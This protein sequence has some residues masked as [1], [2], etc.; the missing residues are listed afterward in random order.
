M[1]TKYIVIIIVALLGT[2]IYAFDMTRYMA[3]K[4]NDFVN[5][6]KKFFWNMMF[7][8]NRFLNTEIVRYILIVAALGMAIFGV[9]YQFNAL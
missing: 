6:P 8:L 3:F 5:Y 7:M 2:Y 1:E 4:L 9:Y